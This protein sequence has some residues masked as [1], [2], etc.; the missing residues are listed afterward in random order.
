MLDLILHEIAI[1]EQAANDPRVPRSQQLHCKLMAIELYC[2]IDCNI[3]LPDI[4]DMVD[5]IHVQ[6]GLKRSNWN[7]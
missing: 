3:D 7:A 2:L 4:M 1:Y 6:D 5:E